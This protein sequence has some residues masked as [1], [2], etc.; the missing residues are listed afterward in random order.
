MSSYIRIPKKCQFC[1]KEF[2]AKRT[3]TMYCS[4]KCA[5]A[6]HKAMKRAQRIKNVEEE[7]AND[8]PN[9]RSA[10]IIK[11][12]DILSLEE[13]AEYMGIGKTT[14]YRYCINDKL[15]CLKINR[16]IFIRKQDIHLMFDEAG[17]YEV[18]KQ[19]PRNPITEFYTANEIAEKYGFNKTSVQK[20]IKSK[21]IPMVC[22]GGVYHY[23]KTHIDRLYS[24]KEADPEITEWYS[25]EEIMNKYAM[26]KIAV[27]SL[28]SENVVP[29]KND[30]G[31]TLY[32]KKH[33]DSLLSK[34]DISE[35]N[36]EKWYTVPEIVVK[37]NVSKGWVANFVHKKGITKTKRGNVGYY[38]K[39]EF[40]QEYEK[41]YPPQEWYMVEDI[42]EK[43]N[44]TRDSVY[45]FV[46]RYS[47]P[48][49]QEG[50]KIRV[51]KNHIDKYFNYTI[52]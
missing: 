30:R 6:A 19:H 4:H 31:K 41:M 20:Y 48:S 28:A 46:K 23:S 40:D 49:E 21:Q 26:T 38:L 43:Y 5:A 35:I 27:Y 51:S 42:M 13:A 25:V 12:K 34:R 3:T 50:K 1:G 17:N 39:K 10:P 22:I 9:C 33:I 7:A 29:K 2:I 45:A 14:V 8:K 32:S 16:R 47:I 52:V 15:K 11:D 44:L 24:I 37:Y 18:T 36:P